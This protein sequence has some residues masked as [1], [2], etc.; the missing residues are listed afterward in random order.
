MAIHRA[1]ERALI[2]RLVIDLLRTVHTARSLLGEGRKPY[3]SGDIEYILLS[4]AVMIGVAGGRPKNATQLA[5]VV[6]IPRA[7]AQRKLDQLEKAGVVVRKG[8]VYYLG[9]LV[10]TAA[11][12][13]LDQYIDRCL[14]LMKRAAE[15]I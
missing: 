14:S 3:L 8:S 2:G 10:A 7:S 13:A 4:Y 15:S 5:R 6:D 9:G 12:G 1:R 11:G